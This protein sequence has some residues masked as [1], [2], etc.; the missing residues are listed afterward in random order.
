MLM[1]LLLLLLLVLLLV[2]ELLLLL[3]LLPLELLLL[4]QRRQLLLLVLLL[5]VLLQIYTAAWPRLRRRTRVGHQVRRAPFFMHLVCPLT[6]LHYSASH[7]D[8]LVDSQLRISRPRI[9]PCLPGIFLLVIRFL[10][11]MNIEIAQVV[12][13]HINTGFG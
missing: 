7:L 6:I 4:R 13:W 1:L 8:N 11:P 3:E 12:H 9:L 10:P 2:L 5:V